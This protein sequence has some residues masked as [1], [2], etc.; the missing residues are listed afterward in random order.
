MI[1]ADLLIHRLVSYRHHRL[2][3][4][5][6]RI[7]RSAR[8][9]GWRT[10]ALYTTV[11]DLDA[12]HATYADEACELHDVALYMNVQAIVEIAVQYVNYFRM[13]EYRKTHFC[14][15]PTAPMYIQDMG[16]SVNRQLWQMLSL[17]LT[18]Q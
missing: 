2:R 3:T 1:D 18:R 9:L 13:I 8:E 17:N 11:P 12:S 14:S 15:V 7:L 10:V 4:V 16:S 6:I 5:A